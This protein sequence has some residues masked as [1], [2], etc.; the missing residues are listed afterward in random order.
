[1]TRHRWLIAG[2]ALALAGCWGDRDGGNLSPRAADQP[3]R[4]EQ[5]RIQAEEAARANR[6]AEQAFLRGAR[7]P[8]P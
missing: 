7:P 5:A 6:Q 4:H 3:E 1:M 8:E 2:L